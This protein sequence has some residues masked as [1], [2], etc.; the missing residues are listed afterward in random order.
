MIAAA[1]WVGSA[2]V[3]SCAAQPRVVGTDGNG[4]RPAGRGPCAASRYG[5]ADVPS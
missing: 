1:S 2:G 3:P 5:K 4:P